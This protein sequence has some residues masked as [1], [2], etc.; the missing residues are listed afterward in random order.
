MAQRTTITLVEDVLDTDKKSGRSVQ[1]A[2][3]AAVIIMDRVETCA[4]GDLTEAELAG[5]E[6]W[7]AAHCYCMSDPNYT[8]KNTAGAGGTFVG[9]TTMYLNATR[10]G[11]MALSLDST[12]CLASITDPTLQRQSVGLK[13]LGKPP[14]SQRAYRD[15]D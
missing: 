2:I 1:F 4:D 13:W 10:Y 8:S 5:I 14:S 6:T 7:L 9:Q 11:Q 15:R 12:G 3:D